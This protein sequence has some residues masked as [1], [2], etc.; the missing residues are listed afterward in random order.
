[1]P[2]KFLV[3]RLPSPTAENMPIWFGGKDCQYDFTSGG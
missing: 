1:M 2:V 3:D